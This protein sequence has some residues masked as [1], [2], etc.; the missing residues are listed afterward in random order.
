MKRLI[1]NII[2]AAVIFLATGCVKELRDNCPCFLY[3]DLSELGPEIEHADVWFDNDG[4]ALE[5]EIWVEY[6]DFRKTLTARVRKGFTNLYAG[7]NIKSAYV[8]RIDKRIDNG[9]GPDSLY[10][11]HI[12]IPT[13]CEDAWV[14][15]KMERE[16][17]PLTIHTTGRD[18]SQSNVDIRL[19]GVNTQY[20]LDGSIAGN[21]GILHPKQIAVPTSQEPYFSHYI[22]IPRQNDLASVALDVNYAVKG[23]SRELECPIGRMLS[24]A[25]AVMDKENGEP[26]EI[27]LNDGSTHATLNVKVWNIEREIEITF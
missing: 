17:T 4:G 5:D 13:R 25:G 19:T 1:F 26:V 2:I 22:A 10:A 12:G 27:W 11:F 3:I 15:V 21:K 16:F 8:D 14:K 20:H 9:M 18:V 23:E 6:S 7:G 24:D